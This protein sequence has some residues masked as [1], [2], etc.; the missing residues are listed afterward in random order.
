M[1]IAWLLGRCYH[2]KR[3]YYAHDRA[4][5]PHGAWWSDQEMVRALGEELE[6]SLVGSASKRYDTD[7]FS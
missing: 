5:L 4:Y 6:I 3:C 7:L 2:D 1:C